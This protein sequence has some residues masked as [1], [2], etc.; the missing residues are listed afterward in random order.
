[1]LLPLKTQ[2]LSIALENAKNRN[3]PSLGNKGPGVKNLAEKGGRSANSGYFFGRFERTQNPKKTQ[4]LLKKIPQLLKEK[5]QDFVQ[6]PKE[7]LNICSINLNKEIKNW[8]IYN[9]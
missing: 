6:F 4:K 2:E 9:L 5:T 8:Q 1:M 7:L 3:T